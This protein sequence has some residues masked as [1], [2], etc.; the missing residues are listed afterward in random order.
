MPDPTPTVAVSAALL[1]LFCGLGGCAVPVATSGGATV[2]VPG[3]PDAALYGPEEGGEGWEYAR[4]DGALAVA[5]EA[6]PLLA[7]EQWPQAARP[8]LDF[9]RRLRLPA[10]P[11]SLLY[12][13]DSPYRAWYRDGWRRRDVRPWYR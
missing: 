13:S 8:E 1:A 4:R 2:G 6:R 7:T 3:R 5:G 9:D 11:G 10:D 12:F